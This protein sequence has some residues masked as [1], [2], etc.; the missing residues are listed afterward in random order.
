MYIYTLP[1]SVNPSVVVV[2]VELCA[3]KKHHIMHIILVT[4]PVSLP[5]CVAA[6]GES[7]VTCS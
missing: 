3:L 5:R 6:V 4:V 2:S 7:H 1:N